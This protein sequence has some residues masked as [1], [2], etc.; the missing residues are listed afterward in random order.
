VDILLFI[1]ACLVGVVAG[2]LV[3]FGPAV[4]LMLSYRSS[5]RES[6]RANEENKAK[7]PPDKRS[8]T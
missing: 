8:P 5:N 7:Q 2:L 1:L 3:L 6:K 4:V